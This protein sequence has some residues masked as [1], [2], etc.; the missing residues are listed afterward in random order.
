MP[1]YPKLKHALFDAVSA[2]LQESAHNPEAGAHSRGRLTPPA[3]VT[4][5]SAALVALLRRRYAHA[6]PDAELLLAYTDRRDRVAFRSLVERHGPLVLRLC[7]R[8]LG[9]AHAAEDAF[10]A[11]FLVLARRAGAVRRPATDRAA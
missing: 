7:R 9:D 8:L 10:Q 2:G 5:M 3:G 4:S 11:T 6:T 1:R